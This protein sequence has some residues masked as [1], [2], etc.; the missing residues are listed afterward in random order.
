MSTYGTDTAVVVVDMQHDFGDPEIGSLYVTEGEIL[1]DPI[2]ALTAAVL[3]AGGQS[4]FTQDWHPT[5]T[6]HF[7]TSGGLWPAHGVAGTPGAELLPDLVV[8]GP[9]IRKGIDGRDGYSGFSVR[10]PNTGQT[11][12]TVLGEKMKAAGIKHVIVVG[13]AGDYCVG[14]TAIDAATLGFHVEMPLH[15]TRF[16]NL[17]TG[18]DAAM[19]A[20]VKSAGVTVN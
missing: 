6:P 13:L 11:E 10:D 12:A 5:E 7:I 20:R 1:V 16:V 18:D 3:S 15:L 14:E 17:N 4:Y 8:N 2:N 9:V 19:I